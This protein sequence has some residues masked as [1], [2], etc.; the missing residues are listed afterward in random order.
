MTIATIKHFWIRWSSYPA[1]VGVAEPLP[2]LA[3]GKTYDMLGHAEPFEGYANYVGAGVDE[4]TAQ[5]YRKGHTASLV[6]DEAFK[7]WVFEELLPELDAK[8]KGRI[9]EPGLT[10]AQVVVGVATYYRVSIDE[11]TKVIKGP[12]KGSE[13]RKLA[14]YLCQQ[15]ATAKLSDITTVFQLG[16]AGSVSF[17]T[18]QIRKRAKEDPR[19]RLQ[20][21]SLIKSIMKQAT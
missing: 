17:I 6:G 18:H 16:H 19:L 8:N 21:E 10:I 12:D 11:I 15:L 5:F 14:M 9:I 2:W 13:A 1:Y 7:L 3:R 20:I 4:Q